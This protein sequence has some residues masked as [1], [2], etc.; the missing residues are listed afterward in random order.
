MNLNENGDNTT[1]NIDD[2]NDPQPDATPPFRYSADQQPQDVQSS[3]RESEGHLLPLNSHGGSEGG[4]DGGKGR[5]NEMGSSYSSRSS[6][7]Y[8]IIMVVLSLLMMTEEVG[9][10]WMSNQENRHKL[11][12]T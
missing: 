6:T 1:I 8:F 7:D 3:E 5:A 12:V 4:G 9:D 2:D 10:L 11:I